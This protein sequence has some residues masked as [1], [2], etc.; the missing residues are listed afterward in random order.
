MVESVRN[1]EAQAILLF[2]PLRAKI[3]IARDYAKALYQAPN[4]IEHMFPCRRVAQSYDKLASF[5]S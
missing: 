2:I 1:V 3:K 5:L 4:I